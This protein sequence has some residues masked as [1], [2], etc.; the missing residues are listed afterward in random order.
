MAEVATIN[1]ERFLEAAAIEARIEAE[2]AKFERWRDNQIT[3]LLAVKD[4]AGM[5]QET[6]YTWNE[7]T[8]TV[9]V[10]PKSADSST[11]AR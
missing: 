6:N 1:V 4:A 3:K 7:K 8:R 11:E 10:V 2:T 5:D 9:E